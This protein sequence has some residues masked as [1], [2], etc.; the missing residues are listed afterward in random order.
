MAEKIESKVTSTIQNMLQEIKD[1]LQENM[2]AIKGET[3]EKNR[4]ETDSKFAEKSTKLN[5]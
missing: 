4:A 2:T 3:E 1:E 5:I